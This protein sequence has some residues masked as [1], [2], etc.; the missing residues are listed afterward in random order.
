[1]QHSFYWISCRRRF[2]GHIWER[3]HKNKITKIT[4]ILWPSRWNNCEKFNEIWDKNKQY[5]SRRRR[6]EKATRRCNVGHMC[7]GG[8][9][10][11]RPSAPEPLGAY[12]NSKEK[13]KQESSKETTFN[14]SGKKKTKLRISLATRAVASCRNYRNCQL[15]H[16]PL[17]MQ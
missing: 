4:Q 1:M 16:L 3:E 10:V 7:A 5:S 9:R 17:A 8:Y 6:N 12:E 14:F 15:P 2:L 13:L 11:A